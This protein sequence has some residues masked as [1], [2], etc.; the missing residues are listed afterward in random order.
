VS[1]LV[2]VLQNHIDYTIWATNR[3]LVPSDG[4]TAEQRQQDFGTAD[5]SIAGTM[6]HLFRSERAWL[7]RLQFDTP[8]VPWATQEDTNWSFLIEHWPA[9]HKQWQGWAAELTDEDPD[10]VIHYSD[11]KGRPWSQPIGHLVLHVVN[12]ST[13]HRGQVSGFLRAL[14]Q[15]PPPLDFIFF[16]RE[17]TK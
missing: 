13:H 14:G 15:A 12:H 8:K 5:K 10:R 9:L 16:I 1:R 7:Q 11:L 4:L 3:L 6:A 2:D 17:K